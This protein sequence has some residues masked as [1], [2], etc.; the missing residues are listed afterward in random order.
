VNAHFFGRD[1]K[2]AGEETVDRGV[3][4]KANGVRHAIEGPT[5]IPLNEQSSR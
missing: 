3:L 1:F 4:G 5:G 2:E